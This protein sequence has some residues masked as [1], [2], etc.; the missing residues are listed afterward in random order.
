MFVTHEMSRNL[1]TPGGGYDRNADAD[2]NG[3]QH[4]D[5][6]TIL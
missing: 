5:I 3:I 6:L 4:L 1:S 2:K